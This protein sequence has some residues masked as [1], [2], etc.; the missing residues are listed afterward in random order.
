MFPLVS[1]ETMASFADSVT[2]RNLSSDWR[3][4][5]STR[6]RSRISL[7]TTTRVTAGTL[8]RVRV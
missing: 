2:A 7:N 3:S 5:A 6:L 4:A 1:V 8:P